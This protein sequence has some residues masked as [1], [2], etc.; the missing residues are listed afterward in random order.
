MDQRLPPNA[1]QMQVIQK[2][3][4]EFKK[5][6]EVVATLRGPNGCPWDL[7]QTPKS[8]TQYAIEEAYELAEA[9]ESG[10]SLDVQEELGDFLFQVALHSQVSQDEGQFTI[11]DVI[12]QLNAKMIHRHPHVF[13]DTGQRSIE[14]VWLN[15]EKLKSQE[16]TKVKPVFN[17]PRKMP[18][19]QAAHKIGVKTE[20]YKF[21]WKNAS[22]V[23]EKVREE[24]NE[25]EEALQ[26]QNSSHIEHE[27][28]DLLFSVAQLARHLKSDPEQILRSANRRFEDRFN[29][30]LK[31][32]GLQKD[33]FRELPS[34]KMEELWKKVKELEKSK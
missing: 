23:L 29:Q 20:G 14:E 6:L 32:S 28:G 12:R 8:L 16:K 10:N 34:E 27:I 22:E 25:L 24:F 21:D 2:A 26:S 3:A 13:G 30:V 31:L 5:L 4:E 18:A 7:E 11:D 1:Q 33:Q 17:Y 9:I 19:L 15:W